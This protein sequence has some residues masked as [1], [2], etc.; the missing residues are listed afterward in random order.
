MRSVGAPF[1][2]RIDG[3]GVVEGGFGR[4]TA[5]DIDASISE[6]KDVSIES[7][8]CETSTAFIYE[9]KLLNLPWSRREECSSVKWVTWSSKTSFIVT[10]MGARLE[11]E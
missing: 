8:R 9:L 4:D 11:G 5:G 10:L 1:A 2:R 3:N 6:C 7:Y